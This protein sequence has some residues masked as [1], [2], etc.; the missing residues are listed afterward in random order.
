MAKTPLQKI[1][2]QLDRLEK[3]HEKEEAIVEK[4]T[5]IIDEEENED[6]NEN[7]EGTDGSD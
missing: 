2:T 1:K 5:E 3:L 7:W 6:I 4:I